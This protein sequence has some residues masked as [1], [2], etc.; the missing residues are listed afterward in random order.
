MA[1]I[2][3][4]SFDLLTWY[5]NLGYHDLFAVFAGFL[6]GGAGAEL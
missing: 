3:S 4:S 1:A 6:D 5:G 2:C